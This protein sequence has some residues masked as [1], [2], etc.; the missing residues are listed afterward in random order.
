MTEEPLSIEPDTPALLLEHVIGPVAERLLAAKILLLFDFETGSLCTTNQT[1]Q[2]QLGLDISNPIQPTFAEMTGGGETD[3][4]WDSLQSGMDCNWSGMIEGALGLSV[5]GDILATPCGTDDQ[6]THALIQLTEAAP[7]ATSADT[8]EQTPLLRS[9]DA[10]VGTITFDLDGN[11]LSLNDR[12][13]TAM[14]DYG[15]ELV[16]QNHDKIWPKAVCESEIYFDFWEKLRQG[17]TVEGRYKHLTAVG[18]EVWFHC[19]YTP[20]QDSSGQ[21]SQVLQCLMDVSESTYA[22]EKAIEQSNA[23]WDGLAMCTFDKDRHISA[24]NKKM[25]DI[26]GQD[27]DDAIGKHD[28]DFCDKGFA[29]G[30]LYKKTWEDLADGRT[31]HLRIRHRAKD[32]SLVWLA[33]TLI[34]VMNEAGQL[35]KVIKVGDDITEEHEDYIDSRAMLAASEDMIGRAEFDGAGALLKGNKTFRKLFKIEPEEMN[36]KSLKDLFSG[37]MAGDAIYRNFW[38]RMHEGTRVEKT[39]EMQTTDGET[40]YIKAI[41]VPLF[42]PNGNFWKLALFFVDVTASN[43]REMK[44]DERM[45][46][47]NLTQMMIEYKPDGTV[48]D[49][50]EKF[51]S[52]F[53]VTEQEVKGQKVSTLYA[54]DTKE[55][56]NHRKMWDRVTSG[57]S[58]TG[59]FRHRN[60]N[61]EDIWLLGAYS[62]ILDPK[63]NV[64]S[65][66]LFASDITTEKLSRLE[67]RSKLDALNALQSVV[68]YDTA[69]NVLRANDTFLKT[70]GYS[71]REIVGQHHSMF[72]SPDYVQT[73]EYRT[74][75]FNLGKGESYTGRVRRIARFNRD[76][77]MAANY[78]PVRN[79]DGEVTKVIKSGVEISALIALENKARDSSDEIAAMIQGG[80]GSAAQIKR[81]ADDLSVTTKSS[82]D[83]TAQNKAKVEKTLQNLNNASG[84]ISE[85]AEIVEV[86]GEIAV[87]TNLLAFN[88]AI[89]A[90]RAG[91]HGI[92]FSIVADEVRKLAERNGEAARG[93]SRH[94]EQASGLLTAGTTNANAVLDDLGTQAATLAQNAD[95]ISAIITESDMQTQKM[96]QVVQI[97][98]K[99]SAAIEE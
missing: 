72:C 31:Q 23:L 34:P 54:N 93:I 9:M 1:A 40:V 74:L 84:E 53:G 20:I 98:D 29:R 51:M 85:L 90:A 32:Q 63:Q 18:T 48:I 19:I 16:G 75:W 26:L 66:I 57:E 4:Y 3:S 17:R 21:A 39:D 86:V 79:I 36:G 49:V 69:G 83:L 33:T 55:S 64:S 58:E 2:M 59:E 8:D 71:L 73:E 82:Q 47:I 99:L 52:A 80:T 13:M 44:L 67:T 25:A 87:Q 7:I 70:F 10:A 12:A 92:G 45:R 15:E 81:E 77:H 30:T 46:A 78:H 68:E 35:E 24:I 61:D 88:A 5:S 42:T 50:N 97:T 11:I 91:E 14:E 89:E 22:A 37:R 76:V 41:Y 43:I 28:D 60:Q 95:A 6:V 56:D 38:D 62:P 27:P 96:S 65:V 94:V